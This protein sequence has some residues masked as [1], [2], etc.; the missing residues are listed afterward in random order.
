M[1]ISV[2]R[3]HGRLDILNE[4]LRKGR[5]KKAL[6]QNPARRLED[7]LR[8]YWLEH[9]CPEKMIV[10]SG[11][12]TY[13]LLDGCLVSECEYQRGVPSPTFEECQN[14][15]NRPN[16]INDLGEQ[17]GPKGAKKAKQASPIPRACGDASCLYCG[18][19]F[20]AKQPT[21]KFCSPAHRKAHFK[22]RKEGPSGISRE[23]RK[24]PLGGAERIM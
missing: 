3:D 14:S 5:L 1:R 4:G 19:T 9:G 13:H 10:H 16:K 24:G 7:V 22:Q 2:Q 17:N 20:R 12:W 6:I 23:G 11:Q 15:K 21:Q 8:G 18:R